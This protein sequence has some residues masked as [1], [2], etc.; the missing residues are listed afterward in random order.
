MKQPHCIVIGSG[1]GG[2]SAA[3]IMSRNGFR[4]TVLEAHTQAGGC[5]QTFKRQGAV[6]ETGMHVVGSAR[7]GEILNK[8]LNYLGI[9]DLELNQLNPDAYETIALPQGR[10]ELPN[11]IENLA[12][13]LSELFPSERVALSKY[14]DLVNQIGS[15]SSVETICRV[16]S[17]L[18]ALMEYQT[19]AADKVFDS[20]FKDPHL[21]A[22]LAADAPLYGG[23]TAKTPFSLHAFLRDFYCKSAFRFKNHSSELSER[24][25]TR[26]KALGGDVITGAAVTNILFDNEKAVGVEINK[27]HKIDCDYIIST[28]H[29][30]ALASMLQTPLIRPAFR[31][32]LT[33]LPNGMG[34]FSLYLKFK[35]GEVPLLN[36]IYFGYSHPNPWE[37]NNYTELDW[38]RGFMM[39]QFP[40]A[41]EP[42]NAE[43]AVAISYMNYSDVAPW[44][45]TTTPGR[46]GATY[47]EF[48]AR[49]SAKLLEQ[50][51]IHFP[52]IVNAIDDYHSSTP[53]SYRDYT[54]T[55]MGAMYGLARDVNGGPGS[56]LGARTRVPNLFLAGQNTNS[57]GVL[58]VIIGSILACSEILGNRH[59]YNQ[60]IKANENE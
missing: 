50:L 39:M 22:I 11:G 17:N 30:S 60:I 13:R 29:P 54:Y 20:L 35:P 24:L 34:A 10:V 44:A 42:T 19:V 1:L 16:D 9:P 49:H 43:T 58:G 6:F 14:I 5:L 55:A 31:N 47:N 15:A 32:R 2:L 37:A 28:I 53:L 38:P 46:R 18:T 56:H 59:V 12:R 41:S 25:V 27:S 21:K 57:H 52:G 40:S 48:K 51:E 26:I 36:S 23:E 8:L 45:H 33:S 4:V 7:K 3:A